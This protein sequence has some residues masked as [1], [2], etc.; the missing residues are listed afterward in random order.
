MRRRMRRA[1]VLGTIS[2]T[3]M[4]LH[5]H[6]QA[7]T[8]IAR[9]MASQD[10]S[11]TDTF[12]R[13]RGRLRGFIRRYVPNLADA[14]DIVQEVF[15][16]F[17]EAARLLKPIE[18]AGAWLFRV[19]RNRI[20][21]RFRRR[22]LESGDSAEVAMIDGEPLSLADLLPDPDASPEAAFARVL[23]LDELDAALDELPDEQR[24]VFIAHELEGR[25]FKALSD[26]TGIGINTLLSRKRYAVLFLRRRLQSIRDE[27]Q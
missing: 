6:M 13:E 21:D 10:R 14:E 2:G 17:V 27:I 16:E 5:G 18:Q 25:S 11:I 8:D 12:E 1:E 20:S 23:L 24:M 3:V 4:R 7:C 22:R 19:A 15:F 26:E 9:T